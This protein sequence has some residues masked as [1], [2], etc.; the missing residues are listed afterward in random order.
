MEVSPQ[1]SGG[2][3]ILCSCLLVLVTRGFAGTL[4]FSLGQSFPDLVTARGV[5]YPDHVD[6]KTPVPRND[7]SQNLLASKYLLLKDTV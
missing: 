7:A 3:S 6:G 5:D 1:H 2:T 4:F